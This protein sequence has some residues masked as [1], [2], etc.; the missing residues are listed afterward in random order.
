[1][2]RFVLLIVL[3]AA[4]TAFIVPTVRTVR[5]SNG[6]FMASKATTEEPAAGPW[7][8]IAGF[9]FPLTAT[10]EM[11]LSKVEPNPP[12]FRKATTSAGA[13][14][15]KWD[16]QDAAAAFTAKYVPESWQK[17]QKYMGGLDARDTANLEDEVR[18]FIFVNNTHPLPQT[19]HP[20]NFRLSTNRLRS[21]YL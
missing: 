18:S 19:N 9:F 1:M 10:K 4:T 2:F 14:S 16:Q 8:W 15:K 17:R 11:D 12:R 21:R 20:F 7:D 13:K 6:L 5:T 3:V